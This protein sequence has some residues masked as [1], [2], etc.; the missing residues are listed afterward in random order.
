MATADIMLFKERK[1]QRVNERGALQRNSDVF[2]AESSVTNAI[3]L[4]QEL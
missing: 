3:I 4:M 1:I 2:R